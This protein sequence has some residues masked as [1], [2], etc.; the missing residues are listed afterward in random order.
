MSNDEL[1]EKKFLLLQY[2]HDTWIEGNYPPELWNCYERDSDNTNNSQEAYNKS[3]K[4]NI[5]I[6]HPNP[7]ILTG[8][9]TKELQDSE[10]KIE[11]LLA[12]KQLKHKKKKYEIL[13]DEVYK[14][15][16]LYTDGHYETFKSYLKN[17]GFKTI[18][19]NDDLNRENVT[20][21]EAND[22]TENEV[23]RI[24]DNDQETRVFTHGNNPY[25]GRTLGVSNSHEETRNNTK[26]KCPNCNKGFVFGKSRQSQFRECSNCSQKIHEKCITSLTL[27]ICKRC[28]SQVGTSSYE[29][30]E[31]SREDV[32]LMNIDLDSNQELYTED[33]PFLDETQYR[34]YVYDNHQNNIN[35]E[36][37]HLLAEGSIT[38]DNQVTIE[39]H[40][41][42]D[43]SL[44]S[45]LSMSF[46]E[47]AIEDYLAERAHRVPSNAETNQIVSQPSNS[48]FEDCK[49]CKFCLDK[50]KYGGKDKLKQRCINKPK[51]DRKYTKK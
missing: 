13:H 43:V 4:D 50:K 6:A 34:T 7:N 51:T 23:E 46:E 44:N 29:D 15:K 26:K 33:I 37:D 38:T 47:D 3:L 32:V 2:F 28:Q 48:K 17:V 42:N 16:S 22:P 18:L 30:E 11:Q 41:D 27:V 8:Y 45:N 24:S 35:E 40:C 21:V 1:E 5:Q 36:T 9:L 19:L 14:M 20:T 25:M 39:E 10:L 31:E 49:K 12:G